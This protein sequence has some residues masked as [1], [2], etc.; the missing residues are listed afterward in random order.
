M[1][2][3]LVPLDGT[4]EAAAALPAAK[5]L[6]RATGSSIT[7]VRVTDA[8]TIGDPEESQTARRRAEDEMRAATVEIAAAGLL[9]DW[10]MR[11]GP[12]G[13]LNIEAPQVSKADL[14]VVATHARTDPAGVSDGGA[15]ERV[16]AESGRSILLLPP[17]G[18]RL[19]Q[20]RTLLVPVD[21]TARGALALDAAALLAA[22]TEAR[23]VLLEVVSPAPLWRYS[24]I[25]FGPGT[26][27]DPTWEQ[28]E[29]V[30]RAERYLEGLTR[31]L[32]KAGLQV[33]GR[34]LKGEVAPTIN[35]VANETDADMVVMSTHASIGPA[36]SVPGSVA[37]ALAR[38]SHRPV[39][40]VRPGGNLNNS[41]HG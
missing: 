27:I 26:D 29:P 12:V 14:I 21:G 9:V 15:S 3:I 8:S 41:E 2:R 19:D 25:E 22:K 34:V 17:D 7:L 38:T 30:R 20:I 40:L 11:A 10:L 1:F 13:W 24:S 6:A 28:E 35:A 39:L 33:G 16:A 32:Q 5:T 31:Q 18:K 36:S 23:L 4:I 37:A